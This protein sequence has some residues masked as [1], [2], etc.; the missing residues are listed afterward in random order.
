MIVRALGAAVAFL[1]RVPWLAGFQYTGVDLVRGAPAF[2]LVGAAIGALVGGAVVVG[3]GLGLPV[4]LAATLA[5]GLEVIF[6]GA[7]HLDG[8]ADSA[9]GLAGRTPERTLQIMRDHGV[10]VYGTTAI[11]LDLLVKVMAVG[12]LPRT[13]VV[14][15]LIAV[16]AVSRT[17]PLPLAAGLP[18]AGTTGT[19]RAFVDG[20]G[21]ARTAASVGIAAVVAFVAVAAWALAL[22]AS[23]AMVTGAVAVGT[24][25]RLGGVTGDVLGA[26]VELVVLACLVVSVVGMG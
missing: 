21:W 17:A 20:V 16:Y 18:Y 23:L 6:T 19:G 4:L 5:I 22:L 3:T 13:D 12:S 24:R 9:D 10:G 25:R 26:A 15:T 11:A 14:P 7:L 8:L 2:P 1:T